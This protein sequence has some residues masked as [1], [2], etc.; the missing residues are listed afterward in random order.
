MKC[1]TSL[2]CFSRFNC[3]SR[4]TS[5]S[6][7]PA[8]AAVGVG[9]ATV[10]GPVGAVGAPP[11]VAAPAETPVEEITKT[12]YSLDGANC[13]VTI[14][15]DATIGDLK[16]AIYDQGEKVVVLF[17]KGNEDELTNGQSMSE[18]DESDLYMLPVDTMGLSFEQ[19]NRLTPQK[20][21][22]FKAEFIAFK[23]QLESEAPTELAKECID[24]MKEER[25][26]LILS[27]TK[28][29][30]TAKLC[31]LKETYP[32][33]FNN[34]T[35]LDLTN[36][37]GITEL[38]ASIGG[39]TNLEILRL[40]DTG[41]TELPDSI[42]GLTGLTQLGL[43]D[44]GVTVLP[45][46]IGGLRNLR[47]LALFGCENLTTLPDSIGGLTNLA[48]LFLNRTGIT[49]VPD[50]IGKLWNLISLT[51]GKTGI[52]EVP[53]WIGG[54]TNLEEL[55]LSRTGITEVPDSIGD[56]TN[57]KTLDLWGCKGITQEYVDA[58]KK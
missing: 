25:T 46:A 53:D 22:A 43:R 41:I 54:L 45:D 32:L 18:Y 23:H 42:G 48:Q 10:A 7:A 36:C 37:T 30:T 24:Q 9:V 38:P 20:R 13:T 47:M 39:L 49:E 15:N 52:T 1:I 26:E 21:D 2:I 31:A 6:V 16:K 19:V 29:L 14:P 34:L 40:R 11:A 44:T 8:R 56:L 4:A 28:D 5:A 17:E 33:E 50:S 55:D 35:L 57:L 12:V 3:F 27:N 58:L 51:L